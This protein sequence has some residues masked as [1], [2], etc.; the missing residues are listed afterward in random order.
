MV[1]RLGVM[2]SIGLSRAR[3]WECP[4]APC[5]CGVRVPCILQSMAATR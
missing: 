3:V 4:G 5:C 1:W 2:F